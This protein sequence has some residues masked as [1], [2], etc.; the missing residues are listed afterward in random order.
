M[1]P[2]P[3]EHFVRQFRERS[4]FLNPKG[5]FTSA[6]A[7]TSSRSFDFMTARERLEEIL[8]KRKDWQGDPLGLL[9]NA[10]ERFSEAKAEWKGHVKDQPHLNDKAKPTGHFAERINRWAARKQVLEEES[11]ALNKLLNQEEKVVDQD[12][13]KRQKKTRWLG[14]C[15]LNDNL[16][17]ACDLRPVEYKDGK[18]VFVDDGG[19]V[20]EYLAECK[21]QGRAKAATHRELEKKKAAELETQQLAT[22]K[23]E[24]DIYDKHLKK[25]QRRK[26]DAA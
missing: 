10:K 15:K 1:K 9:E 7:P 22:K 2:L 17:A 19:S 11:R 6:G 25:L 12:F 26:T 24:K 20:D 4:P 13:A 23:A 18:P 8:D 14:V 21:L 16:I 5:M 3:K